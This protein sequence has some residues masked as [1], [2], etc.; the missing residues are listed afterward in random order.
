M[1]RRLLVTA[2]TISPCFSSAARPLT[3]QNVAT[4]AETTL[5][6]EEL[7]RK[8]LQWS[9][10]QRVLEELRSIIHNFPRTDVMDRSWL[11]VG[12]LALVAFIAFVF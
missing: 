7:W 8:V 9:T 5:Q 10:L 3:E 4:A 1:K 6:R 12:A 2:V 11:R